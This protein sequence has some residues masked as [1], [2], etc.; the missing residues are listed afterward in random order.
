M[1][2][3]PQ[4]IKTIFDL[5]SKTAG[6]FPFY[7]A[8]VMG[9]KSLTFQE[10]KIFAESAGA[11][12][13]GLGLMPGERV[14]ILSENSIEWVIAF[15]G[16]VHSS[17]TALCLDPMNQEKDLLFSLEETET[18]VV[19]VSD[20]LLPKL[21]R[22]KP[23]L[24]L[25]KILPLKE[26]FNLKNE[27]KRTNPPPSPETIAV[28]IYTSGTMGSQK[29]V[30]LS[31]WNIISTVLAIHQVIPNH[32]GIRYLNLLP[33][34]HMFGITCGLLSLLLCG[35]CSV[36]AESLKSGIVMETMRKHQ[37]DGLVVVPLML[38]MFHRLIN[39]EISKSV[40]RK[41]GFRL[42]LLLSRRLKSFGMNFEKILFRRIHQIF[43][44]KISYFISGGAPLEP[45]IDQFFNSVGIPVLNGYGLTEL[46]PSISV[47]IPGDEEHPGSAGKPLPGVQVKLGEQNEILVR[48]PNIMQGYYKN[49]EATKQVVRGEWFHTGDIG[50]IDPKG[51]LYI[52][53]RLKNVIVTEGGLKIFPEEIE[54]LLLKCPDVREVCVLEIKSGER[55][56][57]VAAIYPIEK[58]VHEQDGEIFKT[59]RRELELY[60]KDWPSHQRISDFILMKEELPKTSTKKIR[61]NLLRERLENLWQKDPQNDPVEDGFEREIR[62][63]IAV[64]LKRPL[65]SVSLSSHLHHDLGIDS[66][67]KIELLVELEK[68]KGIHLA[69]DTAFRMETVR[70][71]TD[72]AKKELETPVKAYHEALFENQG[73]DSSGIFQ[74]NI[75]FDFTRFLSFCMIR[76]IALFYFRLKIRG[77]ENIPPGQSC[78][79]A[80]NHTSLL[81]FPLILASLPF[82]TATKAAAPAAKDFFF[83]NSLLSGLMQLLFRAFPLDRYGNFFEG[84]QICADLIKTGK[85][86]VLFPEGTRSRDGKLIEFKP[87]AG[88][89]AYELGIPLLPVFIKGA[90]ESFPKGALL[91]RPGSI[92]IVFGEPIDIGKYKQSLGKDKAKTEIYKEI[93]E[94][95]KNRILELEHTAIT[96]EKG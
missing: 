96:K 49:P 65:D 16:I 74:E 37:I 90:Y 54:S 31:H 75:L 46:S 89:L 27:S 58:W 88:M 91:P 95:V 62:S 23:S 78:I 19:F 20:A 52:R 47:S 87:G 67:M 76:L 43:G 38:K 53:G 69:E 32:P 40:I 18:T 72:F 25:K 80:A 10:L 77:K 35:G 51:Y 55:Q 92:E 83:G 42:A 8:L 68:R 24:Q 34:S 36:F 1:N 85:L 28:I 9:E 45:A 59:F 64:W 63:L 84:L 57:I 21:S 14:G 13:D 15:M 7:P 22:L 39:E 33:L 29:G 3:N 61:R 66:L 86:L 30:M 48:G 93:T 11:L 17:Y 56:K 81:D 73:A 94:S 4:E 41:I 12:L 70:D 26:I 71:L 50:E 6:A 60:Q 79:L 44:G 5:L 82:K 2:K